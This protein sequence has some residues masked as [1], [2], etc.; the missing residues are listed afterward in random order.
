M[1]EKR[2]PAPRERTS[3]SYPLKSRTSSR[4]KQST[5]E[6]LN[7]QDLAEIAELQKKIKKLIDGG[8]IGSPREQ[9]RF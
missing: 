3:R 4:K 5:N 1:D 8:S 2:S 6:K 7:E 9:Q